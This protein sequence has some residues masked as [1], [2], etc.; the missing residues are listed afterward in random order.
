MV[1]ELRQQKSS[2]CVHFNGIQN[3]KCEA[4]IEYR[5]FRP[6]KP[7]GREWLPCL[8]AGECTSCEKRRWPT[9]EEVEAECQAMDRAIARTLSGLNAVAEDAKKRG[10]GKGHG[11]AGQVA[12][13]VCGDGR[14]N[15]SVSGYNGHRHAKCTTDECVSFME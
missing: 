13:P 8:K 5:T 3:D 7:L 1:S 11:G 14:I 2:R 6:E 10:L 12:C 4:G 15:Y 9:A